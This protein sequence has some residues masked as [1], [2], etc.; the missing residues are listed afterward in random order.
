MIRI[1]IS[2]VLLVDVYSSQYCNQMN[3]IRYGKESDQESIC[4]KYGG[5]W[6]NDFKCYYSQKY[7]PGFRMME[8]ECTTCST[9]EKLDNLERNEC[10]REC[11]K[12]DTCNCFTYDSSTKECFIKTAVCS[13]TNFQFGDK[14]TYNK[15]ASK[16]FVCSSGD[17]YSGDLF[18][19][20]DN[21]NLCIEKCKLNVNCKL[22]G[23][24]SGV[25]S[26]VCMLKQNF[27][28]FTSPANAKTFVVSC[29]P[30]PIFPD[31]VSN[32]NVNITEIKDNSYSTCKAIGSADN[33]NMKIPWPSVGTDKPDFNITITGKN[34]QNCMD[35]LN[36]K[37]SG[38]IAYIVYEFQQFLQFTGNFKACKLIG[39]ND[40]TECKYSC[41]CGI[42]YCE[43]VH[44]RIFASD[45]DGMSICHYEI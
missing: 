27:C 25:S 36:L 34:L 44:I 20:T 16:E 28:D 2:L 43:A 13:T 12:R 39:G 35:F 10:S 30:S 33:F 11:L 21:P 38:V 37:R 41:S 3:K 24:V 19:T 4:L 22:I 14:T 45:D 7:I 29:I 32:Y 9:S 8:G 40:N 26:V 17:C 31:W 6:D 18:H 42:D 5:C 15:H 1:L 23:L